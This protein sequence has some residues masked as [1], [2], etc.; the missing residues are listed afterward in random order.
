[1]EL[2]VQLVT[3]LNLSKSSRIWLMH[4]EEDQL[5]RLKLIGLMNK[6]EERK[7]KDEANYA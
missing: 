6:F 1:M 7:K 5:M 4:Q 2:L 3:Q